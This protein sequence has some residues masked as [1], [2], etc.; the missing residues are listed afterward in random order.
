[1]KEII[2]ALNEAILATGKEFKDIPKKSITE[3]LDKVGI[4]RSKQDEIIQK[5]T[6]VHSHK[7]DTF[8]SSRTDSKSK[9]HVVDYTD[10]THND[11]KKRE[12]RK[13]VFSDITKVN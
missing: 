9:Y 11:V 2:E 6:E 7:S 5:L 13:N 10:T 3:Y 12:P 4:S 1:M 8:T